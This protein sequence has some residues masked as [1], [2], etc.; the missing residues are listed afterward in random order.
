MND[1]VLKQKI[2]IDS[3]GGRGDGITDINGNTFYVPY[4]VPGDIVDVKVN[5]NK[6]RL[7]H[8]HEK[9]EH[10]V[11]AVCKHFTKCGGCKLQHVEGEFYKNWKTDLIKTALVNQGIDDVNVLPIQ[12]SPLNSR[13]RTS[14]QAIG[15]GDGKLVLGYAEKSS[16]NL[17]DIE[18]CPILVSEIA[19]FIKPLKAFLSKLLSKQQ[20][21]TIQI[22]KGDNGLD[23]IFK[24]K[25]EVDLDLRMDLAEF[26]QKHDLARI[27]WYDTSAKRP[28]FEMLA[29]RRKP[30]VKFGGNKVFFPEGSFLQATMQ[31]Q[32]A[33]VSAMLEGI[34]GA[35]RVVDLF[36]GCGTFSIAAAKTATVHAVE[37]NNDMLS[38]LKNSANM[39]TNIK[40]V[41]SELRD[42]FLRPLLPHELNKYD[43]AIIDPPRAGARHQMTEIINS[44]IKTLIMVSCNPITF[45]RDVQGLTDAGFT[46]GAV[47]PVDQFLFSPHL[48]IISVFKR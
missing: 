5:G 38:A 43:V 42:L 15:R 44:D 28:Y 4:T 48:E 24:G 31:G 12:T 17:I 25:G 6:A 30:Y 2:N 7:R 46:M 40:Q 32:E 10:R 18:V 14:L 35:S 29:E 11:D 36:S 27:S 3:L 23:V 20:K 16:H 34:E 26:A 9:S 39:M 41:T 45:A 8:I 19:N 33:L 21:I 37:N 47:R 13:R 22:T 1:N